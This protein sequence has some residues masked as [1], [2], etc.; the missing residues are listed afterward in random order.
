[1]PTQQGLGLD[2]LQNWFPIRHPACEEQQQQPVAPGQTRGLHLPAQDDQLL[3][4]QGVLGEQV[5]AA[6]WEI[7]ERACHEIGTGGLCEATEEFVR[8][9]GQT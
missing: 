1:M 2:D 8:G 5:G 9:G 6:A 3:A 7:S 4:Q